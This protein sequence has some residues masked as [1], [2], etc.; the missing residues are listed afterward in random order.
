MNKL[1]PKALIIQFAKAPAAGEAKTRMQPHLDPEQSAQ[2]QRHLVSHTFHTLMDARVAP[3]ELWVVGKDAE[4]FFTGLCD[5]RGL[6][7]TAIVNQQGADL[8][9]RMHHAFEE[10]LARSSPVILVG[11]D[12]P[13]F[14]GAYLS[15]AIELLV[16]GGQDAVL[17]PAEDG[18]YVMIGLRGPNPLAFRN[19]DWGTD[20]VLVQTRERLTQLGWCW[21]EMPALADIDEPEDLVKLKGLGVI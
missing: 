10:T 17:G 12:C 9:E 19:I 15:K 20:Q 3:V 11:S 6:S 7:S 21:R 16:E 14:T 5:S 18:G 8:G 1:Y 13:F 4:G 2:L